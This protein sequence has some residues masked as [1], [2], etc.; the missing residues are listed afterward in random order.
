MLTETVAYLRVL[1]HK[2]EEHP[3]AASG[4]CLIDESSAI[5]VHAEFERTF[6]AEPGDVLGAMTLLLQELVV[7]VSADLSLET[8][9][10][11]RRHIAI[12]A[13]YFGILHHGSSFMW[14]RA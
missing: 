12:N 8:Y 9:Q 4:S 1:P 10:S 14:L 2:V 3:A 13:A 7:L 5:V 6:L 11:R